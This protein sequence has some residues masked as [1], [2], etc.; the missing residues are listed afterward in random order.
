[1]F[2]KA[3]RH[4]FLKIVQET[5]TV[6]KNLLDKFPA[7]SYDSAQETIMQY[8]SLWEIQLALG[9]IPGMFERNILQPCQPRNQLKPTWQPQLQS[10]YHHQDQQQLQSSFRNYSFPSSSSSRTLNTNDCLERSLDHCIESE[11]DPTVLDEDED[12]DYIWP[13]FSPRDDSF[14]KN[15]LRHDRKDSG[16]FMQDDEGIITQISPKSM[17]FESRLELPEFYE[18]VVVEGRDFEYGN[19]TSEERLLA[20][21]SVSGPS[22]PQLDSTS[23]P[24]SNATSSSTSL[25]PS[26][27]YYKRRTSTTFRSSFSVPSPSSFDLFGIAPDDFLSHEV[28]DDNENERNQY[29]P[30]GRQSHIP[31]IEEQ[32]SEPG[33]EQVQCTYVHPQVSSLA[34]FHAASLTKKPL[35]ADKDELVQSEDVTMETSSVEGVDEINDTDD[36]DD[37]SSRWSRDM[38]QNEESGIEGAK[39]GNLLPAP[40][41]GNSTLEHV[42]PRARPQLKKLQKY[43]AIHNPTNNNTNGTSDKQ[44]GFGP[45]TT[46][47]NTNQSDTYPLDNDPH[48]SSHMDQDVPIAT[49]SLSSPQ[50]TNFDKCAS[51]STSASITYPTYGSDHIEE[52]EDDDDDKNGDK[53]RLC[54]DKESSEKKSDSSTT[55]VD[56]RSNDSSIE[57]N[58]E[59]HQSSSS[60]SSSSS[61]SPSIT[62]RRSDLKASIAAKITEPLCTNPNSPLSSFSLSSSL[63]NPNLSTKSSL[64][65]KTPTSSS[66]SSLSSSSTNTP[67]VGMPMSTSALTPTPTPAPTST[68]TATTTTTTASHLQILLQQHHE[69][70]RKEQEAKERL[71]R[72][73]QQQLL[74]STTSSAQSSPSS[75]LDA[76]AQSVA[77]Y[78]AAYMKL[79]TVNVN[80]NPDQ[81]RCDESLSTVEHALTVD[82]AKTSLNINTPKSPSSVPTTI[83]PSSTM[84]YPSPPSSTISSFPAQ[85]ASVS[86]KTSHKTA[87]V[88]KPRIKNS[89]ETAAD[90]TSTNLLSSKNHPRQV[91][92]NCGVTKTPLWRRTQDRQHSLCNA[93]GLYYK[94]YKTSR[95][96][97]GRPMKDTIVAES[98]TL[99]SQ[100]SERPVAK[101]RKISDTTETNI[102]VKNEPAEGSQQKQPK[103]SDQKVS[104][105]SHFKPLLPHPP[106]RYEHSSLEQHRPQPNVRGSSPLPTRLRKHAIDER[107]N[108]SEADEDM[109]QDDMDEDEDIGSDNEDGHEA[110][111]PEPQQTESGNMSEDDDNDDDSNDDDSTYEGDQSDSGKEIASMSKQS[112]RISSKSSS[113]MKGNSNKKTSASIIS[114][115]NCGQTQTPLWRK[116]TRGRSICN[117]CGLYARLHQRDR[118]ITMRKT[119][120]A[121]RKR[122]YSISQEKDDKAVSIEGGSQVSECKNLKENIA[123]ETRGEVRSMNIPVSFGHDA[124]ESSLCLLGQ[125]AEEHDHMLTPASTASQSPTSAPL[126]MNLRTGSLSPT[127]TASPPTPVLSPPNFLNSSASASSPF[128]SGLGP[129]LLQQYQQQLQ[130][131]NTFSAAATAASTTASV[132]TTPSNENLPS[133]IGGNNWLSQLYSPQYST[134]SYLNLPRES[135]TLAGLQL[136]HIQQQQQQQQ[137]QNQSHFQSKPS[138]PLSPVSLPGSTSSLSPSRPSSIITNAQVLQ[139]LQKQ[140]QQRQADLQQKKAQSP[141]ILDSSRF[142]RLM[143]QMSKP[144]LSMFLTILEERCGALRHRLSGEDDHVGRVDTNEMMSMMLNNPQFSSIE[145]GLSSNASNT[146]SPLD[147]STF[148][149]MDGLGHDQDSGSEFMM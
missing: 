86:L 40:E 110:E 74:Q 62:S 100:T 93:C 91:C 147:S 31:N 8:N 75:T 140:Q 138:S 89:S 125:D 30:Q 51:F 55:D 7:E 131:Q 64:P 11:Q 19:L 29:Q 18:S 59:I 32:D 57:A 81:T 92:Y 69:L 23:L 1:M 102:S 136:Q 6:I 34:R 137:Q 101:R 44:R 83:A 24:L 45:M 121:R 46:V 112:G 48:V 95:P 36:V 70:Q 42:A 99:S 118:P 14:I 2:E 82:P 129:V 130:S 98:E 88:N 26:T 72:E 4:S 126:S 122:D 53:N 12:E 148:S 41:W 47:D 56:C 105:T 107:A 65:F 146:G 78:M 144:Q 39:C 104:N 9:E 79:A 109:C 3:S 142:T 50:T 113:Q 17:T 22:S 120:I 115:A 141:L 90:S 73:K 97:A 10:V 66:F 15:D 28:E 68:S 21:K 33:L 117:A 111:M 108:S 134:G 54:I 25:S 63:S 84:L 61:S 116:D 38:Y 71:E 145:G 52:E 27:T 43:S 13:S 76:D 85:S 20:L 123:N 127:L 67:T 114:C 124:D 132:S 106:T 49:L 103:L 96:L 119:K 37:A 133:L 128:L 135:M 87:K 35:L 60:L 77:A 139:N 143:N 94:Q 16:V 58:P 80:A 5:K 149:T